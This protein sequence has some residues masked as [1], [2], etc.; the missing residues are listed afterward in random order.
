MFCDP[1]NI[2]DELFAAQEEGLLV[3]FAGAGVSMDPPSELPSFPGL[4]KRIAEKVGKPP[5]AP[6]EALDNV[7]GRFVREGVRVHDLCHE[8]IG[9]RSKGPTALHHSLLKLFLREEDIRIVTTNFDRHFATAARAAGKKVREY[10]APALPLGNDF[11]GIVHLH[12]SVEEE[13]RTLVL[14]DHDFGR[15]YLAEGWAR[16]FLHSL[17]R[18]YTILFVGYSHDDILVSYLAYGISDKSNRRF[19]VHPIDTPG[20]WDQ[21]GVGRI[22]YDKVASP[23][24]HANLHKGVQTWIEIA[25]LQPLDIE[26]RIARICRSIEEKKAPVAQPGG[27]EL[28]PRSELSRGDADFLRRWLKRENGVMWF[29]RHAKAF[30][31]VEWLQKEGRLNGFFTDIL[32]TTIEDRILTRWLME[33]LFKA[34]QDQSLRLLE[35]NGGKIGP[36]LWR[37]LIWIL[38]DKDRADFTKQESRAWL[39]IA[40]S[41]YRPGYD[42]SFWPSLIERLFTADLNDAALTLLELML[43]PRLIVRE[44]IDFLSTNPN[45]ARALYLSLHG[46][47]HELQRIWSEGFSPRLDVMAPKLMLMLEA[48]IESAYTCANLA[49]PAPQYDPLEDYRKLIEVREHFH[50]ADSEKLLVDF[51]VAV[52]EVLCKQGHGLGL[53]KILT[54]L[55]STRP[56]L[57]RVGLFALKLDPSIAVGD[58]L[59]VVEANNLIFPIELAAQTDAQELVCSIYTALNSDDRARIWKNIEA[60]PLPANYA[61]LGKEEERVEECKDSADR[62][63]AILARRNKGDPLADAA[64][65]RLR[66]RSPDIAD[67][68]PTQLEPRFPTAVEVVESSPLSIEDMLKQLPAA[69]IE[70]F[71]TYKGER[72]PKNSREGLVRAIV[73]AALKDSDWGIKLM[74][75]LGERGVWGGDL[76]GRLLWQLKWKSLPDEIRLWLLRELPKHA[77]AAAEFN[78]L[79]YFFLADRELGKDPKLSTAEIDALV[80]FSLQTWNSIKG[81]PA[82]KHKGPEETDY[83]SI[84]INR[85]A[86]R[87]VEFW[88]SYTEYYKTTGKQ[89]AEGWPVQLAAVFDDIASASTESE[90]LGLA[91]L[92]QYLGFA[93]YAAPAWTKAK[94]YER[95]RFDKIGDD[96]F[97]VWQPLLFYARFSREL[98]VELPPFFLSERVRMLR[99]KKEL[100]TRFVSYTAVIAHSGVFDVWQDGWLWELVKCFPVDLRVWWAS[101]VCRVV[102]GSPPERL[103]VCWKTWARPYWD[104][105][106]NGTIASLD[107]KEANALVR[108]PVCFWPEF[109]EALTLLKRSPVEKYADGHVF[110]ELDKLDIKAMPAKPI[111]EYLE[112]VLSKMDRHGVAEDKI[113]SVIGKLQVDD[114]TLPHLLQVCHNLAALGIA[115]AAQIKKEIEQ[116]YQQ[117]KP[118]NPAS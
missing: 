74:Q 84:A 54:W 80:S 38:I 19:A 46:D 114:T 14:T 59:R 24:E 112:W 18:G 51:L 7:L 50:A 58:K 40:I 93:R 83:T 86:G 53:Q 36:G 12:G 11:R 47:P 108:W 92:A 98:L 56:S 110:Y 3:V 90:R 109:S 5:P 37:E 107:T 27:S 99:A 41:S 115:K 113:E 33:C 72:W 116:R 17:Y 85:P 82:E 15:A 63:A 67:Y 42:L 39:A 45:S 64:M 62:F 57:V 77:K 106:L 87:I 48:R 25:N 70:Y 91:I 35:L 103:S 22:T 101:D 49:H 43:Q 68:D 76:W 66:V 30:S 102:E 104:G 6:G 9:D 29:C 100:V 31:L 94:L 23:N 2:P 44:G 117:Q 55:Q 78:N 105:R 96:A 95:L 60:G 16:V 21:L 73:G 1:L 4:V 88:L 13:A 75:A 52:V 28:T 89:Q 71:L 26:E 32:P 79:T 97:L 34:H 65:E 111:S 61:Y 81:A 8:I 118:P 10:H 20:K 69:N